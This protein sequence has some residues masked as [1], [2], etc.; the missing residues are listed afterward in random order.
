MQIFW[1]TCG[2]NRSGPLLEP[3]ISGCWLSYDTIR[4][5]QYRKSHLKFSEGAH[6]KLGPLRLRSFRPCDQFNVQ[7]LNIR[8]TGLSGDRK[9]SPITAAADRRPLCRGLAPWASQPV[10]TA[11]DEHALALLVD[12]WPLPPGAPSY[13]LCC[14]YSIVNRPCILE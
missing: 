11:V 2:D 14:S 1:G 4:V 8:G 5:L 3:C 12:V 9:S 6:G 10:D 13:S 7:A